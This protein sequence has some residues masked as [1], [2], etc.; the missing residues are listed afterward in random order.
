MPYA[1]CR[2]YYHYR[3]EY[4]YRRYLSRFGN[5][6][7]G[8]LPRHL[9]CRWSFSMRI[10]MLGFRRNNFESHAPSERQVSVLEFIEILHL[11]LPPKHEMTRKRSI[12]LKFT[13]RLCKGVRVA[14]VIRNVLQRGGDGARGKQLLS[15]HCI[16]ALLGYRKKQS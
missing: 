7:C 16:E 3:I 13:Y 6:S 5:W 15:R 14:D 8:R 10:G 11:P 2:E 12:R 1:C 9:F 4:Y